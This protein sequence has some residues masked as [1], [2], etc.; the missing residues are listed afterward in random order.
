MI[1]IAS[2]TAFSIGQRCPQNACVPYMTRATELYL[3]PKLFTGR[4]APEPSVPVLPTS[5]INHIAVLTA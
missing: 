2:E 3:R 1:L 4:D 5:M